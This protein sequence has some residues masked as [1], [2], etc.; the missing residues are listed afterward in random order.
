MVSPPWLPAEAGTGV[1]LPEP[2]GCG[3]V[4]LSTAG[5]F[6]AQGMQMPSLHASLTASTLIDGA[7]NEGRAVKLQQTLEPPHAKVLP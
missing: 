2:H 5:V 3:W 1:T 7:V 4:Q 6:G